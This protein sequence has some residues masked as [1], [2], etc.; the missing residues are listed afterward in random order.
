MRSSFD[1][2]HLLYFV[3]LQT[4]Q[5][6]QLLIGKCVSICQIAW[7]ADLGLVVQSNGTVFESRIRH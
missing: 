5:A 4:L 2:I 6:F 1:A 3:D 7:I